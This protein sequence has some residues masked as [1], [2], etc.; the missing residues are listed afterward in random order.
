MGHQPFLVLADYL[1]GAGVAVLRV[2][3][4]GVGKSTGDFGAATSRDFADDA[5]AGVN[6][7]KAARTS[8]PG[9]SG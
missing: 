6:F 7:S 2:D 4:R 5:L 3:D 8:I 1:P 9:G